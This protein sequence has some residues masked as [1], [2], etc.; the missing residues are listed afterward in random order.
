MKKLTAQ[1]L[2]DA[3][4]I[5]SPTFGS[6]SPE[7][8]CHAVLDVLPNHDF[9]DAAE[10]FY[11]LLEEHKCLAGN[12]LYWGTEMYVNWRNNALAEDEQERAVVRDKQGI[13][14]MFLEFLAYSLTE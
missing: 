5:L 10:E 8:M 6:N 9:E 12:V 2:L 4:D 13:R 11:N 7:F 1:V 3:A 14:F